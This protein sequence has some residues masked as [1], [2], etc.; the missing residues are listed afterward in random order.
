MQRVL[1]LGGITLAL[2]LAYAVL[3]RWQVHRL[4]RVA[5]VDP[6]LAALRPGIPAILYFTSPDCA[7]CLTQQKPALRALQD[8]LGDGLQVIEVNALEDRQAADRWGVLSVPTTFVL[9]RQ[10]Q[11]R[12]VNYGVARAEKLKQQ[13][14]AM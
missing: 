10:G 7:P 1:L 5:G 13:L 11:P 12:E 6:L 3:R 8:T 9:D 4:R 14:Q 2:V